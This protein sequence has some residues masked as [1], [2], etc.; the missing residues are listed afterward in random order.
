MEPKKCTLRRFWRGYTAWLAGRRAMTFKDAIA[1]VDP[2]VANRG[3]Q[4]AA[5]GVALAFATVLAAVSAGEHGRPAQGLSA[6]VGLALAGLLWGAYAG[7]QR[8]RRFAAEMCELG[9]QLDAEDLA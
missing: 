6:L 8:L 7:L 9:R 4:R 1:E 5:I 3:L 2:A